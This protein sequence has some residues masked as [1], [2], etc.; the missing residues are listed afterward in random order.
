MSLPRAP[1]KY[2][3]R[4]ATEVLRQLDLQTLNTHLRGADVEL[5]PNERVIV[6]SPN[7]M[8]WA[9]TVNDAGVISAAGL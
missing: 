2:E 3:Q 5:G 6:R 8:R 1:D 7:G 4:W 9:I